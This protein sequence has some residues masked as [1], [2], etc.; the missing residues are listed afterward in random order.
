[1]CDGVDNDCDGQTDEGYSDIDLD[2]IAS[3]LDADDDGDDVVDPADNCPLAPNPD[4]A[5]F[6]QDMMGDV[7][8]PDDDNDMILDQSDCA[9]KNPSV[10]PGATEKCDGV[11][12]DCDGN[13]D[14]QNSAGCTAYFLDKDKDGYGQS[15]E[16]KCLCLPQGYYSA[17][18]GGDCN[19]NAGG[20]HPV[21]VEV[22]DGLDNDCDLQSDEGEAS[23]SCGTV[24][25]GKA[26][27]LSGKCIILSCDPPF[28]DKNEALAD[29]CETD[30]CS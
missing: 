14:G 28:C 16:L 8:D 30:V 17:E 27:C 25:H 29:G 4:Q 22:C 6:D 24:P 9:P 26:G 20:V 7:C 19:D 11:D 12:N 5:D 18:T 21:A 1:M 23:D 10:R 2:G 15:S 13:V 3:C